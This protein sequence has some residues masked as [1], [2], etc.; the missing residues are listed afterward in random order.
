MLPAPKVMVEPLQNQFTVSCGNSNCYE[1]AGNSRFASTAS[2]ESICHGKSKKKVEAAVEE[3]AE[4]VVTSTNNGGINK[5]SVD[6][7]R[8]ST[9]TT[10]HG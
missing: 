2:G 4:G 5:D 3:L 6:T 7:N 8:V 1:G 9:L 10:K